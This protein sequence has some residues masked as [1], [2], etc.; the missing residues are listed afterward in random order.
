MEQGKSGQF[1]VEQGKARS[2]FG[3]TEKKQ[4]QIP[5]GLGTAR[6]IL[7]RTGKAW[8]I[9]GGSGGKLEKSSAGRREASAIFCATENS[10]D[11][12]PWH[13][14]K[15]EDNSRWDR[16][17]QGQLSVGQGKART[18]LGGTEK[19]VLG[20]IGEKARTNLGG[21]EKTVLGR[22]GEKAR[23]ILGGTD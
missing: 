6:T 22:M 12:S 21:T 10:K 17:K 14:K 2:I 3:G 13:R 1:S 15:I 23:T 11:N 5:V 16:E 7:G 19:T 20:R 18:N 9:L 4:G 8:T